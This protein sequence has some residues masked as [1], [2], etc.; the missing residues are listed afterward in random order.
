VQQAMDS[1]KA[2]QMAGAMAVAMA[3]TIQLCNDD[4]L[5]DAV[6]STDLYNYQRFLAEIEYGSTDNYGDGYGKGGKII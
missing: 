3:T 2:G 6:L 5:A 4:I 1:A